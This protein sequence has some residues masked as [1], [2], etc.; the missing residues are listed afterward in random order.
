MLQLGEYLNH[1][2]FNATEFERKLEYN[3][4]N[5]RIGWT[6]QTQVSV[7]DKMKHCQDLF[8]DPTRLPYYDDKGKYWVLSD[9]F[10]IEDNDAAEEVFAHP[11][12]DKH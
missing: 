3:L 12:L 7:N 9:K 8:D 4:S 1:D 11:F 5:A 2:D 6:S 10:N